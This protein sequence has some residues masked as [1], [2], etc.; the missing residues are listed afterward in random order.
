M[1][2]H[3]NISQD[4]RHPAGTYLQSCKSSLE[5]QFCGTNE[6]GSRSALI[7]GLGAG[8][9]VSVVG[10]GQEVIKMG[11]GFDVTAW[12]VTTGLPLVVRHRRRRAVDPG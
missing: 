1:G 11:S 3:I 2:L 12:T 8:G 6:R 9:L 4:A 10:G 7:Q 5:V